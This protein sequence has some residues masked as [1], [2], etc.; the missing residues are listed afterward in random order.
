[1][2]TNISIAEAWV[3][4]VDASKAFYLDVLG[5]VYLTLP[6]P[7]Y[8]PDVVAAINRSLDEGGTFA[9]GLHVADCRRGG[10]GPR[11]LRQRARARRTRVHARGLRVNV[12]SSTFADQGRN[13][14][15]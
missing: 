7:P 12:V 3:K 5:S 6:G 9:L 13:D 1:M 2:I 14:G 8:S 11:Q 4:D 10:A 15:P